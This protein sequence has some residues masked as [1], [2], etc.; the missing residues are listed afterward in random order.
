M[1]IQ[2]LDYPHEKWNPED[3]KLLNQHILMY[4]TINNLKWGKNKKSKIE[5]LTKCWIW[6][7]ARTQIYDSPYNL[8]I[9]LVQSNGWKNIFRISESTG[10][11]RRK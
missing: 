6:E 7:I 8:E 9:I 10:V 3:K 11:I 1:K 4:E 5:D 2:D